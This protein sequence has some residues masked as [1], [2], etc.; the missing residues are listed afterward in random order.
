[1][2]MSVCPSVCMSATGDRQQRKIGDS[3]GGS[4][5]PSS[6]VGGGDA[7]GGGGPELQDCLEVEIGGGDDEAVPPLVR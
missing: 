7:N 4:G 2:Y 3:Y 5:E 1:M 6:K